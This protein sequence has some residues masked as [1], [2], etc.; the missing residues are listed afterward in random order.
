MT[1]TL[2]ATSEAITM[3]SGVA[4]VN[5]RLQGE[6]QTK[7]DGQTG[8]VIFFGL[9]TVHTAATTVAQNVFGVSGFDTPAAVT[10]DLTADTALSLTAKWSAASASN[11][12]TGMQLYEE[13]LN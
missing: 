13:A 6:L 4:S 7:T 3:G 2:L 9:L 5:W 11:T 1:G 12:M 8:T 10:V